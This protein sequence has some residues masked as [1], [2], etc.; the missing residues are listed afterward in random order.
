VP[1]RTFVTIANFSPG[2]DRTFNT[3][4]VTRTF[5]G[6][7]GC[8]SALVDDNALRQTSR[9]ANRRIVIFVFIGAFS[10]SELTFTLINL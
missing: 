1:R 6:G 5:R 7:A 10:N 8:A 9:M 2:P 4:E 3:W